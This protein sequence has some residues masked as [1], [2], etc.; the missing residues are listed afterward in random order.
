MNWVVFVLVAAVSGGLIYY[1]GKITESNIDQTLVSAAISSS[2]AKVSGGPD[3]APPTG[4]VI[5]TSA[6]DIEIV[7]D[8]SSPKAVK[9]FESLAGK[10]FYDGTKFHRVIRGFMI[11]GGDPLSKDDSKMSYWGTGGPGY[12][13]QDEPHSSDSYT[14]GTVAMANAGPDTN[15]SQFFI[16]TGTNT[17]QLDS[18][19]KDQATGKG[20]YT[21]FGHVV[22][23][24][25]VALQIEKVQTGQN[26]RPVKPV[27][28][29]SVVLK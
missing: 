26:D 10:G 22:R 1:F 24:M 18:A 11:Q 8:V 23:G 9:N 7:F 17:A 6:G 4:A 14:Q 27:I 19:M 16:M 12:T 3:E 15:G 5:S 28:V 25:D 29:K 21:I 20:K 2:A 13:F